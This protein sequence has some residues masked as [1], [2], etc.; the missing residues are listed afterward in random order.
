MNGGI[1]GDYGGPGPSSIPAPPNTQR[2]LPPR[3]DVH[4]FD[5]YD[6][7]DFQGGH[8]QGGYRY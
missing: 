1:N 6:E 4:G 7:D 5:D 8:V 2:T 3:P